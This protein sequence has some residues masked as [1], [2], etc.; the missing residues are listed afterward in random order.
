MFIPPYTR[1]AIDVK[2]KFHENRRYTMRDIGRIDKR[3]ERLEYYT[4]LSLLEQQARDETYLYEDRLTEKEKYGIVVEQFDGFNIAD[5]KNPDLLCHISFNELK[6]YKNIKQINLDLISSTGNYRKT[7][8]AYGLNYTEEPIISQNTATKATTVQP[9]MFGSYNDA[10]IIL[11][12]EFDN[13]ISETYSPAVVSTDVVENQTVSFV[14][15]LS[16]AVQEVAEAASRETTAQTGE[17]INHVG[18]NNTVFNTEPND[19][20]TV[21]TIVDAV[22]GLSALNLSGIFPVSP[23]GDM[24]GLSQWSLAIS[25]AMGLMRTNE[26]QTETRNSVTS[27]G[28]RVVVGSGAGTRRR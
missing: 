11:R 19:S 8:R 16:T 26:V 3:V 20:S 22:S 27:T 21:S 12:P 9:Y 4:Q 24:S 18:F 1:K 6:P 7:A 5:T 28:S 2:F 13:W 25:G 15:T 23:I 14:E 10:D 17:T